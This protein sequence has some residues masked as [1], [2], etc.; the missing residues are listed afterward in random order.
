MKFSLT[1]ILSAFGNKNV[2]DQIPE[3][4]YTD[5]VI[6]SIEEKAFAVSDFNVMYAG[7]IELAGYYYF[8]TMIVGKFKIKTFNGA[9]LTILCNNKPLILKS[10]M[11]ELESDFSKISKQYITSI[12]FE[13]DKKQIATLNKSEIKNLLLQCKK[14]VVSFDPIDS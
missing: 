10:D 5:S 7:L 13:T 6:N 3:G 14:Q 12:D 8:K 2:T 1:K 4:N 11:E 9:T